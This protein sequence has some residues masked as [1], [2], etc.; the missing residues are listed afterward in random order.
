MTTVVGEVDVA[1]PPEAAEAPRP[2]PPAPPGLDAEAVRALLRREAG[3]AARR[4]TD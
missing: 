3:R 2:A 1:A 4:W